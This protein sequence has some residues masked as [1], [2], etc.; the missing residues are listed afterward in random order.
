[1]SSI[2]RRSLL[3]YSGTTAAGAVLSG[4]AAA[5]PAQAAEPHA[6]QAQA[7]TASAD[8]PGPSSKA[9]SA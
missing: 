3:G 5:Q 8:F 4:A 1:M 7:K 2:S 6:V 9:G